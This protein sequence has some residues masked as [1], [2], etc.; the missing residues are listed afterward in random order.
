MSQRYPPPRDRSPP[1][2]FDRRSSST[3]TP[4]AVSSSYRPSNESSQPSSDRLPPR[5]PRA[6]SFRGGFTSAPRGRGGSFAPRAADSWDRDRERDREPRAQQGAFR[7]DDD[8]SDWTRRDDRPPAF[9]RDRSYVGRERSASPARPRRDSKD[10]INPPFSRAQDPTPTYFGGSIRGSTDRG[11]SRGG[12]DRSRGRSSFIGDRERD[13]F[14]SRSRSRD[15]WRDRDF[16]RPR[17][18]GPDVDRSGRFERRDYDRPTERDARSRDHDIWQRDHSPGRNSVGNRAVSP[19][20]TSSISQDRKLDYDLIRKPLTSSI[21]QGRDARRETE[22][23]YFTS[24]NDNNRREL[25]FPQPAPTQAV[26]QSSSLGLD[27]GPPPPSAP[28]T[29]PSAP[30]A[31]K[32]SQPPKPFKTEPASTTLPFQPPSGP[33][34]ARTAPSASTAQVPQLPVQQSEVRPKPENT[35][36]VRP[37]YND[38]AKDSFNDPPKGPAAD[39]SAERVSSVSVHADRPLPSNVPS[40]PRL[41]SGPLYKP[42]TSPIAQ[43]G[44]L[45][46]VQSKFNQDVRSIP[47]APTGPRSAS[48]LPPSGPRGSLPIGPASSQ[49]SPSSASWRRP[50]IEY[51][52]QKPSIMSHM[53]RP[54]MNERPPPS[55]VQLSPD[56]SPKATT[57]QLPPTERPVRSSTINTEKR[58]S[59]VPESGRDTTT[60]LDTE[61]SGPASEEESAE[62]EPES[63]LDETSYEDS[64]KRHAREMELLKAKMPLPLLEDSKVVGLLI[65][66]QLLGMIAEGLVPDD[67]QTTK[68]VKDVQMSDAPAEGLPSPH[69]TSEETQTPPLIHPKPRGR[70]LREPPVNPIPTPPIEELPYLQKAS[71]AVE[72]FDEPIEDEVEEEKVTTLL[73]TQFEQEA[74]EEK[75]D[76]IEL[77]DFYRQK[78]PEWKYEIDKYERMRR[79]IEATP[80]PGS[81]GAQS[82]A[83][84]PP[85]V[86]RLTGRAARNATEFDIEKAILMSQQSARE[87]EERREREAASNAKPNYETEAFVPDMLKPTERDSSWRFNDTNRL[88]P[89][90]LAVELMQYIPPEDDFTDEEQ[91]RFITAF[92]QTPKKWGL[93]ADQIPGRTYQECIVHYYLTKNEANYKEIWR[94]SQPKRRRGRAATK[95]RST[96]LLSDLAL[97]EDP[98]TTPAPVTDSG[99]PRRAAAPTFGDIPDVDPAAMPAAKRLAMA[100]KDAGEASA[101]KPKGRKAGTATK[102]RRTKAQILADNQAALAAQNNLDGSPAKGR[103]RAI[104]RAEPSKPESVLPVTEPQ[105]LTPTMLPLAAAP[106]RPR[107]PPPQTVTSYWSVPE[108]QKFRQLVAYYGRDYAKIADFMKTKSQAMIKNHYSRKGDAELDRLAQIAEEKVARGE[109]LGKAP[110]PVAPAKR[111]YDPVPPIAPLGRPTTGNTEALLDVDRSMGTT[112]VSSLVEDFPA[113]TLQRDP[114]GNIVT[115]A[116]PHGEILQHSPLVLPLQAKVE[117]VAR[118]R[119]LLAQKIMSGPQRGQFTDEALHS[120]SQQRQHHNVSDYI[121]HH[122]PPQLVDLRA[123]DVAV[124]QT[125]DMASQPRDHLLHAQSGSQL[126]RYRGLEPDGPIRQAHSRNTSLVGMPTT[127]SEPHAVDSMSMQQERNRLYGIGISQSPRAQPMQV[128]VAPRPEPFLA[129]TSAQQHYQQPPLQQQQQ[130][131]P[132]KQEPPKPLP[133]K[134]S[135][136]FDLLSNDEPERPGKRSSTDSVRPPLQTPSPHTM[137][138]AQASFTPRMQDDLITRPSLYGGLGQ[139]PSHNTINDIRGA[140]SNSPAPPHRA[141][142]WLERFDPRQSLADR[143]SN[144]SPLHAPVPRTPLA[145]SKPLGHGPGDSLRNMD[146]TARLS[147]LGRTQISSPPRQTSTPVPQFRPA[148]AAPQQHSR[149]SSLGFGQTHLGQDYRGLQPQS[150]QNQQAQQP[151]LQPAV[152]HP[153]SASGTPM[154]S[155]HQHHRGQMS[156]DYGSRR[157]TIQEH[158][159]QNGLDQSRDPREVVEHRS[160]R[161]ENAQRST[162]EAHHRP[163]ALPPQ[164]HEPSRTAPDRREFYRPESLNHQVP[165]PPPR[166]SQLGSLNSG[167]GAP[168]SRTYNNTPP[169]AGY[170]TEHR[171]IA[172]ATHNQHAHHHHHSLSGQIGPTSS[173]QQQQQLPLGQKPSMQH[174]RHHHHQQGLGPPPQPHQN[175]APH[176]HQSQPGMHQQPPPP[177]QYREQP[178][179]G[180]PQGMAPPQGHFRNYSQ[181]GDERR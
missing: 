51:R 135:N 53:N 71:D 54:H 13:L 153:Q 28:T 85:S 140:Y 176:A 112:K 30:V 128:S 64:E 119:P 5:G 14:P 44:S 29:T 55:A 6:D 102:I 50:Q 144:P 165:P 93:I 118:E 88:V 181:G 39:S 152:S 121:P 10:I 19:G 100:P 27:Y 132:V 40:G 150:Q 169:L 115:K 179:F 127:L 129:F 22:A 157:L 24:R 36:R 155:M 68:D 86:E 49:N 92:C 9:N 149:I 96:A 120:H 20:A 31:E 12:L 56:Q 142:A 84:I 173:Q 45:P 35:N 148:S 94:R 143:S 131:S 103:A 95:P 108:Q 174:H 168:P 4:L 25:S 101:P 109:S 47:N 58:Q 158:K 41:G 116:S 32:P 83:S 170:N 63:E 99:R 38:T 87:E 111:K 147:N 65:R 37:Q 160:Q 163:I 18:V 151:Q 134:R 117:D 74:W 110:S 126:P 3:Y 98:E 107:S 43:H 172:A 159:A 122:H 72:V 48:I 59:P 114:T 42:K 78:F 76:L 33:K 69:E 164:S 139:H 80:D 46:P 166:T 138:Q 90:E 73:R 66:I 171:S 136:V 124:S 104:L 177:Q 60:L 70:P 154:S 79:D 52:P 62:D 123:A 145:G 106:V 16:E 81:P 97:N 137:S 77:S 167:Y 21:L 34:A 7:R 162:H 133:A 23:D 113:N 2:Q 125:R 82:S 89:T 8:R 91:S 175:L 178:R 130:R 17:N 15:G 180:Q 75:D 105:Q 57:R 26:P 11:R 141:E 156:Q 161:E 146:P 1:R 67:V 61:M